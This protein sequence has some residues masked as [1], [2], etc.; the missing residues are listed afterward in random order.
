MKHHQDSELQIIRYE[1]I[2]YLSVF[3]VGIIFRNMHEHGN[4]ELDLV[5]SGTGRMNLRDQCL[6]LRPGAVLILNPYTPH[7][8]VSDKLEPVQILSFQISSRFC[9]EYFPEF[10]YTSFKEID[11]T[12]LIPKDQPVQIRDLMLSTAAY[13]LEEGPVFQLE[14]IAGVCRILA[15]LLNHVAHVR[16]SDQEFVEKSRQASRMRRVMQ[17]IDQNYK[18]KISLSE[19][20]SMEG[21]SPTYLSRCF[22]EALNMTF[23]EYLSQLRLE[24][25]LQLIRDPKLHLIDICMA[26]GFSDGRYM[27]KAF[28]EHFGCTVTEYRKS[29]L[30]QGT[31]NIEKTTMMLTSEYF[32][33]KDESLQII[34]RQLIN[35]RFARD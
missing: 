19:L 9:E 30:K 28:L 34:H 33:S 26:C 29:M 18:L 35:E 2:R 27:N 10:F 17:Y 20:A 16:L 31:A 32:Y 3:L 11:V 14:C 23:Q 8:L 13:Y 4:F 7:E 24:K 21:V 22:R 25:A 12:E 5:I 6:Q 15:Q 1:K